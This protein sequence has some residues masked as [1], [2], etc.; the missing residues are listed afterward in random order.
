MFCNNC[1]AE[2]RDTAIFCK[3]CGA[4]VADSTSKNPINRKKRGGIAVFIL[5]LSISV[6]LGLLANFVIAKRKPSEQTVNETVEDFAVEENKE[7]DRIADNNDTIKEEKSLEEDI[8][9]VQIKNIN[10]FLAKYGISRVFIF[11]EDV[12]NEL[13]NSTYKA[14]CMVINTYYSKQHLNCAPESYNGYPLMYAFRGNKEEEQETIDELKRVLKGV[15]NYQD[16]EELKYAIEWLENDV[17][18]L[19]LSS[20]HNSISEIDEGYNSSIGNSKIEYDDFGRPISFSMYQYHSDTILRMKIHSNYN[21]EGYIESVCVD[22]YDNSEDNNIKKDIEYSYSYDGNMICEVFRNETNYDSDEPN[23]IISKDV[24]TF[25]YNKDGNIFTVENFGSPVVFHY[26]ENGELTNTE[27]E[28]GSAQYHRNDNNPNCINVSYLEGSANLEIELD[29]FGN[30]IRY[31]DARDDSDYQ[32]I[33]WEYDDKGK[34]IN[35]QEND[36]DFF[37]EYQIGYSRDKIASISNSGD[38]DEEYKADYLYD[39]EGRIQCLRESFESEY[40]HKR[41]WEYEY[42]GFGN[43]ITASLY[44]NES[45]LREKMIYKYDKH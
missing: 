40:P 41:S 6:T 2:I 23:M 27:G 24:S 10:H 19:K 36:G 17:R 44:D 32:D 4:S 26:N 35:I 13:Y 9:S 20:I 5:V 3:I 38:V 37:I 42:D 22:F 43:I 31:N 8:G 21:E 33:S 45:V 25:S 16:R 12:F 30:L 11:D 18:P 29:D 28:Y 7:N 34:V 1:G 14:P 15:N 39:Q